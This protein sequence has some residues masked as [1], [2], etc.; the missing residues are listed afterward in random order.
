MSFYV[1]QERI[2]GGRKNDFRFFATKA[3]ALSYVNKVKDGGQKIIIMK[4]NYF[5]VVEKS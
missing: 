4:K 1:T 3:K 5:S 2:F